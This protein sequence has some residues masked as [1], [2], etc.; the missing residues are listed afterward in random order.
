MSQARAAELAEQLSGGSFSASTWT[1][2]E[3][4]SHD[5]P[6]DR[7]VIM[8]MVVGVTAD[9]L[10]RA[11]A[12]EAAQMLRDEIRRR[13]S[14]EPALDATAEDTPEA[15]LQLIIQGLEEIRTMR[16]LSPEQLAA[17]EASLI[18]NV[19]QNISTQ[20]DQIR[21]VLDSS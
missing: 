11:G 13:A 5:P 3:G 20:I 19:R 15:V 16:G 21:T 1:K 7:L 17:L 4:G 12:A 10:H 18:R 8:A 14:Q 2:V 9:E 6:A